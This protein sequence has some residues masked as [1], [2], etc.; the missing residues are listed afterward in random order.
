MPDPFKRDP[1]W[2][3]DVDTTRGRSVSYEDTS[4]LVGDSPA[5]HDVNTDLGRNSRDGYVANDGDGSFTVEVS[6][7]GTTY[8]GTHTLKNGEIMELKGLDVDSI[9]VTWIQNSSYRIFAV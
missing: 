4:F 3:P 2:V 5:V 8:G 9:R 6:D 1:N 7:D